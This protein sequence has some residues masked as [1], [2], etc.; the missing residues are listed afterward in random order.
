[1]INSKE[2]GSDEQKMKQ[3][4]AQRSLQQRRLHDNRIRIARVQLS[5]LRFGWRCFDFVI[6]KAEFVAARGHVFVTGLVDRD[7]KG[8]A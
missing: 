4:F 1:M 6:G 8:R 3:R 5:A 2:R 7:L